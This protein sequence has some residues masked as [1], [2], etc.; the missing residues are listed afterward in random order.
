MRASGC[1]PQLS[2]AATL[3]LSVSGGQGPGQPQCGAMGQLRSPPCC[4]S[5]VGPLS[6]C[7]LK[8]TSSGAFKAPGTWWAFR[9]QYVRCAPWL[10]VPAGRPPPTCPGGC[11]ATGRAA[12]Q[13]GGAPPASRELDPCNLSVIVKSVESSVGRARL[14]EWD[15]EDGREAFGRALVRCSAVRAVGSWALGQLTQP[16]LVPPGIPWGKGLPGQVYRYGRVLEEQKPGADWALQA[17][18]EVCLPSSAL[19]MCLSGNRREAS[20]V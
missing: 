16:L 3:Q 19:C 17:R 18:R 11:W 1:G 15:E 4:L 7:L 12:W 9:R 13:V 14:W 8:C 2:V 20:G 5:T 6:A 10:E